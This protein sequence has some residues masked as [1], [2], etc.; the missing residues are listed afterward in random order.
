MFCMKLKRSL[1]LIVVSV[2]YLRWFW[3]FHSFGWR[4]RLETPDMLTNSQ[5]ISIGRKVQIRKGSRI[6]AFGRID[7]KAP[8]ITIGDRTSIQ[9]YFHCGAAESVTIGQDVLISGRVYISDHDH[10]FD[11]PENSARWSQK[12]T[13]KP[14]VIE[15][16]V[17][18]GEGCVILKGVTIGKRAVVGANAVVTKD[19]PPFTVVCG[20]PAKVIRKIK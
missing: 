17:W 16:G 13:S 18:L 15:D 12:L 4:S 3:R 14:V 11:D 19:V 10:C 9:F 7:G 1:N 8:K 2:N 5:D 20:V 6:E